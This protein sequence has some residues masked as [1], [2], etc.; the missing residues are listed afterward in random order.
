MAQA[1][2]RD[3]SG[4]RGM[5]VSEMAEAG[6]TRHGLRLTPNG[7]QK[8][9][10]A[11]FDEA[12][13]LTREP[14][15]AA[16][17][18]EGFTVNPAAASAKAA[19]SVAPTLGEELA[20]AAGDYAAAGYSCTTAPAARATEQPVAPPPQDD[21]PAAAPPPETQEEADK[22]C[23]P[24]RVS[25]WTT[26]LLLPPPVNHPALCSAPPAPPTAHLPPPPPAIRP[27][28]AAAVPTVSAC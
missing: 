3:A 10:S 25:R 6:V 18:A 23:V 20:A 28:V 14:A 12:A 7:I 13:E 2:K 5:S 19:T 17:D 9:E 1:K 27:A 8:L 11:P 24:L 22:R 21:L 15:V 4:Y 26:H 16:H